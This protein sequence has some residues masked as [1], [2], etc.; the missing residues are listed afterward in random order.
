MRKMGDAPEEGE[1]PMTPPE[2]IL[3]FAKTLRDMKEDK[4]PSFLLSGN[5]TTHKCQLGWFT[6]VSGLCQLLIDQEYFDNNWEEEPPELRSFV[7]KYAVERPG[8]P[9]EQDVRAGNRVLTI[10]IKAMERFSRN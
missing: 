5:G 8:W 10:I 2:T 4:V 6:S 7:R 1:G 9:Q 3:D